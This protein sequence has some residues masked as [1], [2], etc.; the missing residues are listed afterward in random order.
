[1]MLDWQNSKFKIQKIDKESNSNSER[2]SLRAAV[3]QL[4]MVICKSIILGEIIKI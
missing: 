2:T 3:R 1:M 4:H